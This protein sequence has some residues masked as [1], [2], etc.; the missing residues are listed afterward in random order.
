MSTLPHYVV[1]FPGG[2]QLGFVR[3]PGKTPEL[4]VVGGY[5]KSALEKPIGTCILNFALQRGL[6]CIVLE[7]RGQGRSSPLPHGMTIPGMR[8]DLIQ[9]A[10]S[11]GLRNCIGIGASLGAWAMLAAVERRRKLLWGML[12]LAPAI[13]WDLTYFKP[14]SERGGLQRN[15]LG[16]VKALESGIIVGPSFFNDLDDCRIDMRS[17]ILPGHLH[18]IHGAMD[19]IAPLERSDRLVAECGGRLLVLPNGG[20]EISALQ[21]QESQNAFV[22]EC[23]AIVARAVEH[24]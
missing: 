13:D 15:E 3:V 12:A 22:R 21:S 8:D 16:F 17:L 23:D 20:H 2:I 5:G 24:A 7:F 4:L 1:N 6:A 9:A 10:D 11:L 14:L 19:N 18:V